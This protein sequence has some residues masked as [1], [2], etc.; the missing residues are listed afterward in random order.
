MGECV[1]SESERRRRDHGFACQMIIDSIHKERISVRDGE[2]RNAHFVGWSFVH[3][4]CSDTLVRAVGAGSVRT[5]FGDSL[6][7]G[8]D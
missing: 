5:C 8:S 4:A 3:H 6:S 1:S 7:T 2:H